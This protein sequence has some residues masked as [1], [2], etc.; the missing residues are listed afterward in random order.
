[1]LQPRPGAVQKL[2]NKKI[3]ILPAGTTDKRDRFLKG[4]GCG[5]GS[6]SF[7]IAQVILTPWIEALCA[8]Q[9]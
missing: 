7:N 3:N 5:L 4:P 6:G 9:V 8:L 2:N 1:M